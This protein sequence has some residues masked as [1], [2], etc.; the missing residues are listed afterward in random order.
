MIYSYKALQTNGK[1]Q[2]GEIEAASVAQARQLL[3][4]QGLYIKTI[5][6]TKA[7]GESQPI[8]LLKAGQFFVRV[9][10]KD[11]ALF[12]RQLGT[13]LRAG[14]EL[15]TALADI[16]EQTERDHFRRVIWDLRERIQEGASL[17]RAM[18]QHQRAFSDVFIY[19]VKAGESL[20]RLDDILIRLAEL[21]EKNNRLKNKVTSAMMYPM[22][23]LVM[24]V[25]VISVLMSKVVPEITKVFA[26]S[27]AAL[28]VPTQVVIFLSG[29]MSNYWW[30]LL[31]LAGLSIYLVRRYLATTA[32]R[33]VWD[34][35]K[36]RNRL[37]RNL[38]GKVV[39]SRFT[40]NLGILLQ[41]R[42]DL[43]DS[44]QIVKKIVQNVHIEAAIDQT[45]QEVQSGA[46]LARS[47][48]EKEIFPKMVIGMISAGE[49][50]DKLDEMLIKIA[51]IYEDDV[52]SA[53]AAFMALLEP[54]IIV[55]MAVSVGFIVLSIILPITQMNQLIQ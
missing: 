1:E 30:L 37:T 27:Q 53:L 42:V 22:F 51:Q 13:L 38:Y 32:G 10:A 4:S 15:A 11:R 40:R 49:A 29:I 24:M 23:M 21:E 16:A 14:M 54:V 6:P 45:S 41:S 35:F 55:V 19:M 39:T 20:G 9:T 33:S 44:L 12:A 26:K 31:I 50:S 52:E 36:L 8:R 48:R 3:R 17:S 2:S 34:R 43:L 7:A 46:T 47:L 25:V 18:A 5:V 28:P